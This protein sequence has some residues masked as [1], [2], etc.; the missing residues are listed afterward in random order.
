TRAETAL[1]V[2]VLVVTA[3]GVVVAARRAAFARGG[4]V[5]ALGIGAILLIEGARYPARFTRDFDVRPIAAAAQALTPPGTAVRVYP[6]IELN[7]DFYLRRPVV[8]L[9]RARMGELLAG[10]ASGAV[11][12]SRK[13]WTVL[14]PSAHPS[15]R[16][17][18]AH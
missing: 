18:R 15:W 3:L 5:V 11:I 9:D 12:M 17:I 2:A 14:R 7:Y 1:I 8:E 6:D 4:L 13:S 10:P 16:L